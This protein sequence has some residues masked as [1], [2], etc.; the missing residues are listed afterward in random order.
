MYQEIDKLTIS[1]KNFLG[2]IIQDHRFN[3]ITKDQNSS[4]FRLRVLLLIKM[5]VCM[6]GSHHHFHQLRQFKKD[7]LQTYDHLLLIL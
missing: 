3:I 5:R 6:I 4:Q 1:K 2:I 7:N